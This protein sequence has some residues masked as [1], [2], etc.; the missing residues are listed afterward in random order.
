MIKI[1]I[2]IYTDQA[3]E[4]GE[5]H[6]DVELSTDKAIEENYSMIIRRGNFRGMQN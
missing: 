1:D 2:K 4:I 5:C 6:I 3:V